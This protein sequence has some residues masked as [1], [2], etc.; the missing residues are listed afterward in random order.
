MMAIA[1]TGSGN[2]I[3]NNTIYNNTINGIYIDS[4]ASNTEVRNNIVYAST[5]A[6]FVNGG[7]GTVQSNNLFGVDPLFV[8]AWSRQLS[9]T[10]CAVPRSNTGTTLSVV[11]TDITGSARPQEGIP[12]IGAYEFQRA[13]VAAPDS[14]DHP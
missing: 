9:V 8:N 4:G 1:V 10:G 3:W 5:G 12:D 6:D 7:T 14:Q 11:T 2:K 13:G